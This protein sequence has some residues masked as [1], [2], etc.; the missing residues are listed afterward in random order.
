[1]QYLVYIHFVTSV[2]DVDFI[3]TSAVLT[4]NASTSLQCDQV[5]IINDGI[6]ENNETFFVQ[7]ES[8]DDAVNV[9]LNSAPVAIIDDDGEFG[10]FNMSADWVCLRLYFAS[11]VIN[12]GLQDT[13]HTINEQSGVVTVCA[14]LDGET[15]RDLQVTLSTQSN[16][17]VG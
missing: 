1:M 17:A 16:T 15:E 3:T 7:L 6:L 4:F 12:V 14:V 11:T 5:I 2:A 9:S 13:Q 10:L 8:S